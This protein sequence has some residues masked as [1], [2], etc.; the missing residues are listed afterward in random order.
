MI[1]PHNYLFDAANAVIN[2]LGGSRLTLLSGVQN[3]K[4]DRLYEKSKDAQW[5]ATSELSRLSDQPVKND[6]YGWD[7]EVVEALARVLSQFYYGERGAQLIS[8]QL[9][10]MVDDQ[11]AANFLSTQVIDEARHVEIMEKM[12]LHLDTLGP[13]NPFLNALLTDMSRTPNFHEKIIGM[14]LLVEGLALSTFKVTVDAMKADEN[15]TP[16]ARERFQEPLE[17][18]IRDEARHVGFGATYI[19]GHMEKVSSSRRLQIKAR[20][21]V[22]MALEYCSVKWQQPDTEKL[23]VDHI[24][25]V[26]R[27]LADHQERVEGSRDGILLDAKFLQMIIPYADRVVDQVINGY[28]TVSGGVD[29]ILA[30]LNFVAKRI[31]SSQN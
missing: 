29:A 5:N 23:K 14:N 11:E 2:A 21:L 12:I 19:P 31:V 27:V 22:W 3:P 4:I 24:S 10:G 13:I 1:A 20:Q 18:I 30:P 16:L 28:S 9:V 26:T 8:S 15:M 25:V 7:Q 17:Y 6:D